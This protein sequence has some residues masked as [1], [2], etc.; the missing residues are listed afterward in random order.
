MLLLLLLQVSEAINKAGNDALARGASKQQ[1]VAAAQAAAAQSLDTVRS[2]TH[3]LVGH[4]A[5]IRFIV[6]CLLPADPAIDTQ[7]C[8]AGCC[9]ILLLLSTILCCCCLQLVLYMQRSCMLVLPWKYI[10]VTI[11]YI[12][13]P[14]E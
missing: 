9:L 8:C 13:L 11:L 3:L 5:L 14:A 4:A 12:V 10:F 2:S 6:W 7:P 1:A